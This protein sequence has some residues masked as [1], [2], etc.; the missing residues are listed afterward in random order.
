MKIG[1]A[2]GGTGG[3]IFPGLA[4]A[5]ALRKRGHEVILLLS[6]RDVEKKALDD[7][8]GAVII[9]K[10]R[11]FSMPPGLKWLKSLRLLWRAYL[12]C[13]RE[14]LIRKFDALLA[15]GSY[16]SVAPVIA[17]R[18]LSLPVVLHESNVIPGRA[19][20]ML[21]RFATDF[22]IGFNETQE[23]ITHPDVVYTGIP[24]RKMNFENVAI[25]WS[26]LKPGV[27][28]VL[29]TG[30]SRGAHA[31]N[32]IVTKAIA[33]LHAA[34]RQI[35]VIHL[36]GVEDE[37]YVRQSYFDLGIPHVVTAFMHDM[38]NAYH[39]A[40]LA[41]CRAGGS[42]CA[43]L[44]QYG[45]PAIQIPYPHATAQHQK[46]NALALAHAGAS[47]MFEESGLTAERL[48]AGIT[49]LMTNPEKLKAMQQAAL[50]RADKDA[51]GALADLVLEAI[52]EKNKRKNE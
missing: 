12:Q 13:R 32:M 16:A 40:S 47:E 4:T 36:T 1:I 51:S 43:E 45:L 23:H 26:D 35:Q 8:K 6:G 18:E 2:C 17:A 31:L 5:H 44:A 42:T 34:G 19:N 38:A 15:F 27:F 7:W 11:G 41:I 33:D 37:Q 49:T 21:S 48:T 52:H 20:R 50:K 29:V 10:T 39:R 46:A 25:N 14:M 28:T 9:L 22:A 30:G 24:L 3:H